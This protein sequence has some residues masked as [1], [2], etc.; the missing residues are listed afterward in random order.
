M[1]RASDGPR[2][3]GGG[4]RRRYNYGRGRLKSLGAVFKRGGG[5]ERSRRRY[6]YGR[7]RL[8]SLAAI[9]KVLKRSGS[10]PARLP[11]SGDTRLHH[12]A[13]CSRRGRESFGNTRSFARPR[14]TGARSGRARPAA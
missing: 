14:E 8:K 11:I 7:R 4:G 5:G 3:G 6:N 13:Q 9:L 12:P 2:G 10:G 1:G